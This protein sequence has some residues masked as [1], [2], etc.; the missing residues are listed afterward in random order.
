M[1][2]GQSLEQ[3]LSDDAELDVAMIGRE[4]TTHLLA[5][6]IGF[7]VKILIPCPARTRLLGA[8]PESGTD[9]DVCER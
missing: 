4:F 1:E 2:N 3:T 7:P 5:I 6:E 8:H 9:F